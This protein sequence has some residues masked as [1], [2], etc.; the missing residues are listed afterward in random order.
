MRFDI[1]NT[2][3]MINSVPFNSVNREQSS[4]IIIFI[5]HLSQQQPHFETYAAEKEIFETFFFCFSFWTTMRGFT[6]KYGTTRKRLFGN[7]PITQK[8]HPGNFSDKAKKGL[9]T[10]KIRTLIS[11]INLDIFLQMNL[12]KEYLTSGFIAYV[13]RSFSNE[14]KC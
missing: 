13:L 7:S 4:C 9:H 3:R 10:S 5:I 1:K 6:T 8:P 11:L 12:G 14:E 2:K